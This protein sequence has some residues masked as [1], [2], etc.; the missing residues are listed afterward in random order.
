M[1]G[2][3]LGA[4]KVVPIE[5]KTPMSHS[6]STAA[7]RPVS[8]SDRKRAILVVDDEPEVRKALRRTLRSPDYVV[9]DVG[10]AREAL[11][12]L[13]SHVIDLVISDY[14]MPVMNGIDFLQRVR[15]TNPSIRRVL[16]TARADVHTAARVL[17]EGAAHR[18]LLKPWSNVDLRGILNLTLSAAP[19]C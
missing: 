15:L 7:R 14:D 6:E 18:L 9:Y 19:A 4:T 1:L 11:D 3:L 16:L 13:K 5:R 10:S 12:L 17:N 8:S 2:D